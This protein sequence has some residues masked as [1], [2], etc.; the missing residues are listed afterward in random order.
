MGKISAVINAESNALIITPMP[1]GKF[2]NTG[3]KYSA[4]ENPAPKRTAGKTPRF[5]S[6]GGIIIAMNIA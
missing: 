5:V 3:I 1:D 6:D 4:H 2:L